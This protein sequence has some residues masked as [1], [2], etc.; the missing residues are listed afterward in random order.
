VAYEYP[1]DFLDLPK[2]AE[3]SL[4]SRDRRASE[5]NKK[6]ITAAK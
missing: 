6:M 3:I 2:T 5:F 4:Q 1:A